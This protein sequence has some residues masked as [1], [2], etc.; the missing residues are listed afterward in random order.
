MG[1]LHSA[2]S[3]GTPF[4]F[5]KP[6]TSLKVCHLPPVD[7]LREKFIY[8]PE[9]GIVT[10]RPRILSRDRPSRRNG[11]PVGCPTTG[12]Y[13]VVRL[14]DNRLYKLAR[15]IW[16][17]HYGEDPGCALVDHIDGNPSNNKVSNLRLASDTQNIQ[18]RK[19]RK[20]SQSGHKNVY[21]DKSRNLWKVAIFMNRK[22]V[23]MKRFE[24]LEDAIAASIKIREELHGEFARHS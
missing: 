1:F 7:E 5:M 12:G 9:T 2:R 6:T 3:A 19:T 20:D 23:Y 16:A 4:G 17:I 13:L 10:F 14:S 18:N 21:F 24:Y 11:M 8:D 22:L 15:I